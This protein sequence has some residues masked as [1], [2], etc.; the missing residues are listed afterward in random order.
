MGKERS[1]LSGSKRYPYFDGESVT[2]SFPRNAVGACAGCNAPLK[3][4]DIVTTVD[5]RESDIISTSAYVC[6]ACVGRKITARTII[7]NLLTDL[8][9]GHKQ[10]SV[11]SSDEGT[12]YCGEC[13][14]EAR[15]QE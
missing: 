13:E 2:R 14:A 5:I 10:S 11:V 3:C 7:K 8:P 12:H 1:S 4:G 15:K 9:C 6:E